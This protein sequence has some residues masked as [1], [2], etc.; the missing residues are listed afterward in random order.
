MTRGSASYSKGH[1]KAAERVL[2]RGDQEH[3]AGQSRVACWAKLRVAS[4]LGQSQ[5]LHRLDPA[6]VL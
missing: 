6:H 5:L 1:K 4:L 2:G 3:S